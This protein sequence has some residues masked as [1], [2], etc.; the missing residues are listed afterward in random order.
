MKPTT[1]TTMQDVQAACIAHSA[2]FRTIGRILAQYIAT[3]APD[4]AND[5]LLRAALLAALDAA[6]IK[7]PLRAVLDALAF[8]AIDAQAAGRMLYS[9]VALETPP[10]DLYDAA[11][12]M[13]APTKRSAASVTA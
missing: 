12:T 6:R 11:P 8:K 7:A 2:N 9:A 5:K 1:A 4:A 13:V 3:L 10:T